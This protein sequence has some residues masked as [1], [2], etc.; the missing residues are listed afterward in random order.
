M[1]RW[2]LRIERFL[3]GLLLPILFLGIFA[4]QRPG[5][6]KGA[7]FQFVFWALVVVV[8]VLMFAFLLLNLL[9]TR[10]GK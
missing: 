8:G 4:A 10:A 3:V 1:T 6:W 2:R 9:D 5:I 7:G